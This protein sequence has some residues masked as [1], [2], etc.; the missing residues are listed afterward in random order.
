MAATQVWWRGGRAGAPETLVSPVCPIFAGNAFYDFFIG[1]E[2]NPRIGSFD[3]KFFCELRPGLVGWA[4]LNV[5][6][7]VKQYEATGTVSPSL[8]LVSLFQGYYVLDATL[9]EVRANCC[10]GCRCCCPSGAG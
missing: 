1:R 10:C 7:G 2:L 6:C 3:W 8:I 4:L 9:N 5:A